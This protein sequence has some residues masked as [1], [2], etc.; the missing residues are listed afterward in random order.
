MRAPN[1]AGANKLDNPTRVKPNQQPCTE[2]LV[3][4]GNEPYETEESQSISRNAK[5]V[6]VLSLIWGQGKCNLFRLDSY[7]PG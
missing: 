3:W 1:N 7:T 2:P 6:K 5:S 4:Q